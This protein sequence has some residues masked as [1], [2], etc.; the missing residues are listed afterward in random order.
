ME[1][2]NGW[3]NY[4]T[5]R[6]NLELFDNFDIEG[7]DRE[8]ICNLEEGLKEYAEDCVGV[9][10]GTDNLTLAQSYALAFLENVNWK[11]IAKHL[12]SEFELNNIDRVMTGAN[13]HLFGEPA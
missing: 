2:Y 8:Y 5:W 13:P 3:T 7:Y 9:Y 4:E 10:S 12:I 1:K 11:E 6:V